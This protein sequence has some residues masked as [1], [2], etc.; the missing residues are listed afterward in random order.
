VPEITYSSAPKRVCRRWTGGS[1]PSRK[2]GSCAPNAHRDLPRAATGRAL[3]AG[4]LAAAAAIRADVF[5]R[6][7]RALRRF[8]S[9]RHRPRGGARFVAALAGGLVRAAR[10][11][12]RGAD[13]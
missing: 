5:A 3:A 4:T 7:S 9:G 10:R 11:F 1:S 2:G 6:A 8:V 12:A 13:L